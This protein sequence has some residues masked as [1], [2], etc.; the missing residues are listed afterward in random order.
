MTNV[1]R[2]NF[3]SRQHYRLT[4]GTTFESNMS[5]EYN[6]CLGQRPRQ[7]QQLVA[8]YDGSTA[9]I[10]PCMAWVFP[11]G[12]ADSTLDCPAKTAISSS[13]VIRSEL[14]ASSTRPRQSKEMAEA[15]LPLPGQELDF[16]ARAARSI[17]GELAA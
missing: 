5:H 16:Q 12:A 8:A 11:R 17:S 6:R 9:S 10:P 4:D 2:E 14:A 7:R 3:P 15:P 13:A 1:A